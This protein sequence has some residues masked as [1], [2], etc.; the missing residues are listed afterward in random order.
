MST[1]ARRREVYCRFRSWPDDSRAG[2]FLRT[3]RCHALWGVMCCCLSFGLI[4][5]ARPTNTS[6]LLC[7]V[8]RPRLSPAAPAA[9]SSRLSLCPAPPAPLASLLRL[10]VCRRLSFV[11]L[12]DHRLLRRC[13]ESGGHG[14]V[15]WAWW[16]GDALAVHP[17]LAMVWGGKDETPLV[18][19]P[20]GTGLSR[21]RRL[22][23]LE[24]QQGRLRRIGRRRHGS[25]KLLELH[26]RLKAPRDCRSLGPMPDRDPEAFGVRM[27]GPNAEQ[28]ALRP[29]ECRALTSGAPTPTKGTGTAATF[30]VALAAAS[31]GA[32]LQQAARRQGCTAVVRCGGRQQQREDHSRVV[33]RHTKSLQTMPIA[34]KRFG[35]TRR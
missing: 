29:A 14:R 3:A 13:R 12:L 8:F 23:Q 32:P 31:W 33:A 7:F 15:R 25:P 9:P 4:Y 26:G 22:L 18:G 19:S 17:P 28:T 1:T 2:V 35:Y 10:C 6:L 16:S 34:C 30:P 27:V 21:R 11:I 24:G 20:I 5:C